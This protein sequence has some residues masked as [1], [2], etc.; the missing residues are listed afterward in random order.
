MFVQEKVNVRAARGEIKCIALNRMQWSLQIEME[1]STGLA[2]TVQL[3]IAGFPSA[4]YK[5][6]TKHSEARL[7]PSELISFSL[8][9][10]EAASIRLERS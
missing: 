4:E 7:P 8:P 6:I 3:D 5:L 2:K 10:E 1:D 9:I